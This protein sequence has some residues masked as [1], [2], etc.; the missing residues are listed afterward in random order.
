M[1][2]FKA[3]QSQKPGLAKRD[4]RVRP[5]EGFELYS[6]QTIQWRTGVGV[7]VCGCTHP[8]TH[9]HTCTSG[10]AAMRRTNSLLLHLHH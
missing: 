10:W 5:K 9:P 7:W 8:P 1:C 3:I 6:E 2:V 4:E